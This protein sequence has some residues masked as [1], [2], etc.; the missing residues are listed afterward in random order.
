MLSEGFFQKPSRHTSLAFT[1]AR[2]FLLGRRGIL[3]METT[4]SERSRSVFSRNPSDRSSSIFADGTILW[5]GLRT[6]S[7]AIGIKLLQGDPVAFTG[8]NLPSNHDAGEF[9]KTSEEGHAVSHDNKCPL[10]D[11]PPPPNRSADMP[12]LIRSL[13][14]VGINTGDGELYEIFEGKPQKT[15]M[16]QFFQL[17]YLIQEQKKDQLPVTVTRPKITEILLAAKVFTDRS[18]PDQIASVTLDRSEGKDRSRYQVRFDAEEVRFPLNQGIG[19]AVWDHGMC[20][21]AQEIVLYDG[22]NFELKKS[23]KNLVVDDF[24]KVEAFG[25]F[26]NRGIFDIDINYAEFERVEFIAGTDEGKVKSRVSHRE[27]ATNPHSFLF[28]FVGRLIPDT[29]RQ[30]IDW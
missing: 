14:E 13:Q 17:L 23:G 2:A 18:F 11:L 24:E 6:R 15:K 9:S 25:K 5:R 21:H 10:A 28:K 16:E 30:R 12:A 27:F 8:W 29:S 22:F 20:Q 1:H 4:A 19:F 3:S 7:P 26:G